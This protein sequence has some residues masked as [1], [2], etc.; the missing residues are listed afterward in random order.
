M[1]A[2][3]LT[4]ELSLDIMA[5][6]SLLLAI[7]LLSTKP[8]IWTTALGHLV[9]HISLSVNTGLYGNGI[10]EEALKVI[11]TIGG[12]AEGAFLAVAVGGRSTVRQIFAPAVSFVDFLSKEGRRSAPLL[13]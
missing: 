4:P 2:D 7:A 1:Y 5:D 11:H 10:G 13:G 3:E 9:D 6:M 12:I 8:Y